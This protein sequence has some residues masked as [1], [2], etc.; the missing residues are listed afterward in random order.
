MRSEARGGAWGTLRARSWRWRH[1]LALALFCVV[2]LALPA[3]GSAPSGRA[4]AQ[5]P[6][7]PAMPL[8]PAPTPA[9]TAQAD[10][11]D[12]APARL[13]IPRIG[14]DAKILPLGPDA[15]GAMQAPRQGSPKDP[16]WSEVYWW[17]VGTVPGETGNAVIAGHVNRPDGSP[18]TF[19]RLNELRVGDTITVETVS[20]LMLTFRVTEKGTPSVYVRGSDDPTMGRIFGPA[21][22][23]HLN[24]MTCWGEWD[25][26]QYN[27]RLVIYSTLVA[28]AKAGGP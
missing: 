10:Q 1:L 6:A 21:L 18:S 11:R 27:K 22:E 9:A 14:L 28:P 12:L 4:M 24:L 16:I 8:T 25:G 13:I 23:P 19:T 17:D 26:K 3:C 20:G 7:M 15:N 5:Q 2:G